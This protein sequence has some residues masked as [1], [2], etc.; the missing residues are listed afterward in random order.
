MFVASWRRN[1]VAEGIEPNPGP[2]W[3]DLIRACEKR[4]D[5]DFANVKHF[6]SEARKLCTLPPSK[7]ASVI[8][9]IDNYD[10]IATKLKFDNEFKGALLEEIMGLGKN[11]LNNT[12]LILGWDLNTQFSRNW[13]T[14]MKEDITLYTPL[15]RSSQFTIINREEALQKAVEHINTRRDRRTK[16]QQNA[17]DR[18]NNPLIASQSAPG[19]GKTTFLNYL[20]EHISQQKNKELAF[21]PVLVTFSSGMDVSKEDKELQA[22]GLT[23]R[24]IC[25]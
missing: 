2:I 20:A 8:Y 3:Q 1:L 16:A 6:L 12:K 23:L 10:T 13:R 5:D 17:Q 11:Q 14:S 21:I 4:W 22:S 7:T 18:F 24:M 25:R 9:F 15:T 19:G